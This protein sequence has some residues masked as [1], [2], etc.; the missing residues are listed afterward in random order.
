MQIF[1]SK[2]RTA[3]PDW[4]RRANIY[5]EISEEFIAP[6]F[7]PFMNIVYSSKIMEG[8]WIRSI[9]LG[10]AC[11]A[12][13]ERARAVT[14]RLPHLTRGQR[15]QNRLPRLLCLYESL[16]P[17]VFRNRIDSLALPAVS[18]LDLFVVTAQLN[19]NDS[20]VRCICIVLRH[21]CFCSL[22]SK[23]GWLRSGKYKRGTQGTPIALPTIIFFKR[24]SEALNS[25]EY[26]A[27]G[28]SRTVNIRIAKEQAGV[29]AINFSPE[30][31]LLVSLA[32]RTRCYFLWP[33]AEGRPIRPIRTSSF[34]PRRGR[35]KSSERKGLETENTKSFQPFSSLSNWRIGYF[36]QQ[37][38]THCYFLAFFG[39]I[40]RNRT[41]KNRTLQPSDGQRRQYYI[42]CSCWFVKRSLYFFGIKRQP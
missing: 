34:S 31:L 5:T 7:T 15:L 38:E 11:R 26:C 27:E 19:G 23:A 8:I 1:F 24:Y 37:R 36:W 32:D 4:P 16:S 25:R 18:L 9:P 30:S 14:R 28:K 22:D 17:I 13:W 42:I 21:P 6:I 3:F 12:D 39:K 10:S 41:K 29:L 2:T 40:N 35:S 20:R 33:T